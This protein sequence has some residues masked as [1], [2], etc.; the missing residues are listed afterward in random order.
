MNE[1]V[2]KRRQYLREVE[3]EVLR[4]L[5]DGGGAAE[6]AARTV[7]ID[8]VH[9]FAALVALVSASVVVAAE[10]ARPLHEP[11]RQEA[12]RNKL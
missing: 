6:L 9:Q 4:C 10:R 5:L 2:Y 12:K 1:N 11:I 3:E 7:Q 8:G